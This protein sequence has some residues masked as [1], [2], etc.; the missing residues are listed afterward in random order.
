MMLTFFNPL[1]IV[2]LLTLYVGGNA[3]AAATSS[4]NVSTGYSPE[5][6]A[7]RAK[8]FASAG[9][10]F[11][12]QQG[13]WNSL[14][15]PAAK[16][17]AASANTLAG[18]N[19]VTNAAA[20]PMSSVASNAAGANT[21]GTSGAV[22]NPANNPGLQSSIDAALRRVDQSYMDPGGVLSKI[23]GGFIRD[24]SGGT[25]TREGIA[26]GIAGRN[27][28][29][30]IGDVTGSMQNAAYGQGLNYMNQQ[31][32]NAPSVA[33]LQTSP[34]AVTAG[35]GQQQEQYAQQQADAT[36]SD[37]LWQLQA[38]WMGMS[39]YASMISGMSNPSTTTNAS[40]QTSQSNP[41][42]PVGTAMAGVS[43]LPAIL[44]MMGIS[45]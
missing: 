34:G 19:M 32:G 31:V 15:N 14:V 29:Q 13:G 42:A 18:Q 35:V 25:G 43:M 10:T 41:L 22:L 7:A 26:S 1:A 12:A 20:G 37:K 39:P 36:A 28:L 3:P 44:K 2:R 9:S 23:R 11:D 38:P 5:E 4:T 40:T 17:V 30:T 27:Y 45:F 21:F 16:P 33:T 24:N 8:L 6:A